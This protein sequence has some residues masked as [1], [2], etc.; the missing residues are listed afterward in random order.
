MTAQARRWPISDPRV[1]RVDGQLTAR[2][3]AG[4][5]PVALARAGAEHLVLAEPA[6]LGASDEF[7]VR[8]V[9]LLREAISVTVRVDWTAESL[10]QLPARLVCHLPPPRAGAALREDGGVSWRERYQFGRCYYRIGPGFVLIKDTRHGDGRGARY[11]LD[12]AQ[13]FAAFGELEQALY[14]PEA[15][16]QATELF[17]LLGEEGLT[18]RLGDWGTVLPFRM[19]RWPV[20][21]S[22]V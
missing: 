20:P 5:E 6:S 7:D 19:R 1:H 14:L 21:F 2:L 12:E 15:S 16:S 10:G 4:I 3:L 18:L 8:F 22:T 17:H 9:R 11:R 13:A